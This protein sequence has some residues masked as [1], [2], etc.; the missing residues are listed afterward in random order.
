ME[1][2]RDFDEQTEG[3]PVYHRLSFAATDIG[4]VARSLCLRQLYILSHYTVFTLH[5]TSRLYSICE[6]SSIVVS[7]I[8]KNSFPLRKHNMSPL[9]HQQ[10]NAVTEIFSVLR[11]VRN[12]QTHCVVKRSAS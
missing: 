9:Q 6:N 7:L 4:L 12:M 8:F 2:E 3:R 1:L 10:V 11:F 5:V